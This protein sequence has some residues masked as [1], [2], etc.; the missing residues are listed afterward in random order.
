M[1]YPSLCHTFALSSVPWSNSFVSLPV[2]GRPGQ[3]ARPDLMLRDVLSL[4]RGGSVEDVQGVG[5]CG[6]HWHRDVAEAEGGE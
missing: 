4:A 1:T 5:D 6:S 2:Y 3:D